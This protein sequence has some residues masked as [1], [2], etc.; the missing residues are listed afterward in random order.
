MRD[1]HLSRS[2]VSISLMM[3][4]TPESNLAANSAWVMMAEIWPISFLVTTL[5]LSSSYRRKMI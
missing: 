4:S 5:L 3:V 2:T 1:S